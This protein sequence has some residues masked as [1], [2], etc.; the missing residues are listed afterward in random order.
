V[1]DTLIA[2]RHED[3]VT[4]RFLRPPPTADRQG[5]PEW[6]QPGAYPSRQRIDRHPVPRRDR[7]AAEWRRIERRTARHS[8]LDVE[9]AGGLGAWLTELKSDTG[10]AAQPVSTHLIRLHTCLPAPCPVAWG[11][12]KALKQQSQPTLTVNREEKTCPVRWSNLPSSSTNIHLAGISRDR[13][14]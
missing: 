11:R 13:A 4:A 6:P 5:S 3:P 14:V 1:A 10:C 2:G 7:R 9:R 8:D 12:P